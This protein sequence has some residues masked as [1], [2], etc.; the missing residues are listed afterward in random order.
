MNVDYMGAIAQKPS[1]LDPFRITRTRT[2]QI[3][4]SPQERNLWELKQRTL[5][6]PETA[7]EIL[8]TREAYEPLRIDPPGAIPRV[9][10]GAVPELP[11]VA[12]TDVEPPWEDDIPLPDPWA[13]MTGKQIID[14]FKNLQRDAAIAAKGQPGP[15]VPIPYV[16]WDYTSPGGYMAYMIKT[17]WGEYFHDE[18]MKI[19]SDAYQRYAYPG[20][21]GE[22]TIEEWAIVWF[23]E[24]HKDELIDKTEDFL[25]KVEERREE[26]RAAQAEANAGLGLSTKDWL[27]A[28]AI[29]LGV[30]RVFLHQG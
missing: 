21:P 14:R 15:T 30:Y 4:M 5:I 29:G 1:E 9:V 23:L 24:L 11:Q 27:Q 19:Y 28:I 7:E 8:E 13:L 18:Y 6:F 26:S 20:G 22:G 16:G 17:V 10:P 2:E 12:P 3:A 25:K